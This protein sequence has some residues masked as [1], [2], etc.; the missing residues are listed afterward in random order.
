MPDCMF[1]FGFIIP[2][3][4]IA[5]AFGTALMALF[6]RCR[7]VAGDV[8]DVV[9]SAG[10]GRTGVFIALSILLE[11]MRYEGVVDLFQTVKLLR[12]QRQGI[13]QSE[14]RALCCLYIRPHGKSPSRTSAPRINVPRAFSP[15]TVVLRMCAHSQILHWLCCVYPRGTFPEWRMSYFHAL[16]SCI[17]ILS[18]SDITLTF[19]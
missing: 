14:V 12:T 3:I 2:W 9:S 5:F 11:R 13:I 1:F 10:V 18:I 4:S 6:R 7:T 19:C 16:C 8:L 15:R 17:V